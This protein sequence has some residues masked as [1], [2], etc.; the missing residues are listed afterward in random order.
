MKRS[1]RVSSVLVLA[2]A[3][4]LGLVG[5]APALA[6][7]QTVPVAALLNP[8]GTLN[9]TVAVNSALDLRGW[10]VTLDS[11]RGPVLSPQQQPSAAALSSAWYPLSNK[12]LNGTVNAIA[13]IG[14]D[15]YVGGDFTQTYDGAVTNLNRIAKYD[16]KTNTWSALP[17]NGLDNAVHSFAVMGTDLY[18]G[19]GF[20]QTKDGA[21]TGLNAIA[22]IDTTTGAW[23]ALPHNGLGGGAVYA[24]AVIGTKLYVGGGFSRTADN[25]ITSMW[26][27]AI[28][29]GA[30]W[31]S[32]NGGVYGGFVSSLVRVGTDLYV[33][34]VFSHTW[35]NAVTNLNQ[36]AKLDTTTDTWSALPHG[37]M[38][39]FGGVRQLAAIGN[40]LYVGGQFDA[41]QDGVVKDLNHIARFD[42]ATATWSALPNKGLNGDTS[43]FGVLGTD[44]Y[45]GG[46]FFGGTFDGAIRLNNLARFDTTTGAW[47]GL[48]ND[49]LSWPVHVFEPMGTDLYMGGDFWASA[50]GTVQDLRS[51]AKLGP[52]IYQVFLPLAKR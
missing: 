3:L 12:G 11:Q 29:D 1:F 45:V 36:I 44:L 46:M 38:N 26:N 20:S 37:G 48:P 30:S 51:I 4:T 6:Q 22:R 35:D 2:L 39:Q 42:T 43:A 31:S 49:G 19:G 23:S 52:P 34:G 16:T 25:V 14:T 28:F 33:G 5:A 40:D 15:L 50:D 8:D 13:A 21:V 7:P 41:T 17:H 18:V 27:F 10:G 47:S 24:L 32:P 9:M